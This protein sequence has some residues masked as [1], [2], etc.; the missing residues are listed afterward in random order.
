MTTLTVAIFY[1]MRQVGVE[2]MPD[3]IREQA[4]LL[5]RLYHET[6]TT[7]E[8]LRDWADKCRGGRV[9]EVAAILECPLLP[10]GSRTCFFD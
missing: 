2:M 6:R 7:N 9:G 10:E 4:G 1:A 5:A 3:K 8:I